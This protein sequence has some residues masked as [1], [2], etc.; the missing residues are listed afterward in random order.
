[1]G[2]GL[3]AL[4]FPAGVSGLALGKSDERKIMLACLLREKTSV[5]NDGIAKLSVHGASRLGESHGFGWTRGQDFE[6]EMQ[7]ARKNHRPWIGGKI[8]NK[9]EVSVNSR[10]VT[11]LKAGQNGLIFHTLQNIP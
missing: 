3:K 11:P 8:V 5:S 6:K 10:G 7:C 9:N 1:M 2:A 4:G